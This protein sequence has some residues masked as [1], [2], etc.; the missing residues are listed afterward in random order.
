MLDPGLYIVATPIGNLKDITLRALDVLKS[1]DYILSEDTRRTGILLHHY[2]I[3][4]KTI[5]FHAF[6]EGDRLEKVLSDL[7][8]DKSI[9]LV[10][11]AGTPLICDPGAYLI[12]KIRESGLKAY[13]IPGPCSPIA[14]YS[15]LGSDKPFQFLGFISKKQSEAKTFLSKALSYDG[16]SI[17]FDTPHQII[18]TLKLI[19][20]DKLVHIARELTKT[21]EE[22]LSLSAKDMI[23]HFET[24]PLKGEFVVMLEG[25]NS[26]AF[27][28][29]A[30][31]QLLLDKQIP[32]SKASSIAASLTNKSRKEIYDHY[33]RT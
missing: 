7:K 3:S 25:S 4:K 6:N 15:L 16:I 26:V 22:I 28:I 20:P 8:E 13:A 33:S 32:L 10:S 12:S 5:S 31:M 23:H 2:E 27:E 11:D 19:D 14:A 21:F 30:V 29:E 1:C 18:K 24:H 9:A 17:F